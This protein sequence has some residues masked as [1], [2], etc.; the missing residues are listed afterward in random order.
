MFTVPPYIAEDKHPIQDIIILLHCSKYILG[1]VDFRRTLVYTYT[2]MYSRRH[3]LY[4]CPTLD[5]NTLLLAA[6]EDDIRPFLLGLFF[7]YFSC[8][9]IPAALLSC[10]P[11]D[12]V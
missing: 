6:Y 9:A 12:S 1:T 2:C 10:G 7:F 8:G 5:F 11:L 3:R 4:S